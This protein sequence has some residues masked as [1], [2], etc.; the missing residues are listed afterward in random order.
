MNILSV[1]SVNNGVFFHRQLKPNDYIANHSEYGENLH[2]SCYFKNL[3]EQLSARRYDVITFAPFMPFEPLRTHLAVRKILP[4][5]KKVILDIDDYWI[6]PKEIMHENN[7]E[8]YTLASIK[9]CHHITTPSKRLKK[10]INS[11]KLH[12]KVSYIPNGIDHEDIVDFPDSKF[13]GKKQWSVDKS[14]SEVVRFAYVGGGM[15]E[16]DL[17]QLNTGVEDFDFTVFMKSY[18]DMLGCKYIEEEHFSRYG[19]LYRDVDVSV[20]PLVDNSFSYYK[21]P[22]KLIEAGVTKTACIVQDMPPY[23]DYPELMEHCLV[24]KK[25]ESFRPAMEELRGNP[26][27]VKELAEGLYEATKKYRLSE[28]SKKRMEI[29]KL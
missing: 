29:Y 5:C 14:P 26:N 17:E 1:S 27:K 2:V 12:N 25:G 7:L 10:L 6:R 21:S 4:R 20:V 19:V 9:N 3:G 11:K 8:G 13:H 16:V 24:V 23:S 15:H 18:S 22:L 28:L